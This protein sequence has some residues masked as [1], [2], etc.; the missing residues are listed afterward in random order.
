MHGVVEK[1]AGDDVSA[2]SARAI[3]LLMTYAQVQVE[4]VR[5]AT[6]RLLRSTDPEGV[7]SARAP[8]RRLRAALR[9]FPKP[10]RPGHDRFRTTIQ[11]LSRAMGEIRDIDVSADR[12]ARSTDPSPSSPSAVAEWMHTQRLAACDRLVGVLR[13]E[14]F[15]RGLAAFESE[16]GTAFAAPPPPGRPSLPPNFASS[17]RKLK[18]DGARLESLGEHRRHRLRTRARRLAVAMEIFAPDATSEPDNGGEAFLVRLDRFQRELGELNDL[19]VARRLLRQVEDETDQPAADEL[20]KNLKRR[21]KRI[22]KKASA[23][24]A[25]AA[26]AAKAC[27]LLSR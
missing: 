9:L 8:V 10:S 3:S 15:I 11:R 20:L 16:L 25:G 22:E 23:A 5:R 7:H 14:D 26:K 27:D 12:L 1:V 19:A 2:A 4:A 24:L 18:R 6:G 17:W 13:S 21:A